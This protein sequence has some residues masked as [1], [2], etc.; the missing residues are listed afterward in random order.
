MRGERWSK[1]AKAEMLRSIQRKR[2]QNPRCSLSPRLWRPVQ[3][4][5]MRSAGGDVPNLPVGKRGGEVRVDALGCIP[6]LMPLV[7][8]P[9]ERAAAPRKDS[10]KA[11]A[12]VSRGRQRVGKAGR[13]QR[14]ASALQ[15]EDSL[16]AIN[17]VIVAM[18]QPPIFA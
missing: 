10:S 18:P 13:D 4:Q 17:V 2:V 3:Y 15:G 5:R 16:G 14:D 11:P 8:Q 6:I 1:N 7:A 9:A 12:R